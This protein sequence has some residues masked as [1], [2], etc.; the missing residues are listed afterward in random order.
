MRRSPKY[1]LGGVKSVWL[2]LLGVGLL[3]A[4]IT[5]T[6]LIGQC[7]TAWAS[8]PSNVT[9]SLRARSASPQSRAI[10]LL[11]RVIAPGDGSLGGLQ[12]TFAIH[13]QEFQGEPLLTLGSRTTNAAGL[14]TF[15]YQPTWQ[16]RQRLVASVTDADG[17]S[18]AA[19]ATTTFVA[20]DPVVTKNLTIEAARPDGM[21]GRVVVGVLVIALVLVWISLTWVVVRTNVGLAQTQPNL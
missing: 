5:V 14:A 6:F 13:I 19:P 7:S 2:K 11:A 15:T 4:F 8:T 21:I 10:T 18:V 12:V 16:G 20:A 9:L 1:T 3:T 17:N